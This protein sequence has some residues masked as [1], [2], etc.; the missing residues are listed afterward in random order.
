MQ[1]HKHAFCSRKNQP[2]SCTRGKTTLNS[3]TVNILVE[4]GHNY[5]SLQIKI[6]ADNAPFRL[7]FKSAWCW[8]R[9][10]SINVEVYEKVVSRNLSSL[11][12][13][14]YEYANHCRA[15]RSSRL[16]KIK[17]SMQFLSDLVKCCTLSTR[18]SDPFMH[19]LLAPRDEQVILTK[20]TKKWGS[21]FVLIRCGILILCL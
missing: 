8:G 16:L 6:W 20:M 10:V 5:S 9:T 2:G 21:K 18:A 1:Y 13:D 15:N 19:L 7:K 3:A 17:I 12:T 11:M 4:K 14:H